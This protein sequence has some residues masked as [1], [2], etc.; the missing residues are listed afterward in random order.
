MSKNVNELAREALEWFETGT[1]DSGEKFV[2]TKDGR[3]EWLTD[4]IFTA[5]GDMMPDDHRYKF[6]E[7]AL[8][9]IAN[10]DVDLDR[11]EIEADIYTS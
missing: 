9:L 11:P 2:K 1:R 7:E 8:D 5:H 3:P 10:Q 4:L 6:I